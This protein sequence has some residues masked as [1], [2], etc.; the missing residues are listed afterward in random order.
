MENNNAQK[1][2]RTE[3]GGLE[4]YGHGGDLLTASRMY[5]LPPE[6]FVDFSSNMNP[7]GPPLS[8]KEQIVAYWPQ[9]VHYPDPAARGLKQKLSSHYHIPASCI[10]VGN[11]A[12]E[13]IDLVVRAFCPEKTA[14]LRPSFSEYELAI[15]KSG[16]TTVDIWLQEEHSFRLQQ[17]DLR[18][19]LCEADALFIGQPNNPTGQLVPASWLIELADQGKLV[20]VDE[21]FID[22]SAEERERSLIQKAAEHPHLIV[23]RSMTKFYAVP[24]IR[25]GFMVATQERILEVERLQVP[26]SVN[27]LAQR[28]GEAVLEDRKFAE[29]TRQWLEEERP[30]FSEK[31][32]ALGLKVMPSDA[33]YLLL[34]LPAGWTAQDMQR[35]LGRRGILIRDASRFPGLNESYCRVAIKKREDNLKLVEVLERML[36]E[37]G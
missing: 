33:N 29:Q 14:L 4:L 1:T 2:D 32:S 17:E 7:W 34:K 10:C 37:T 18:R 16:G 15:L 21:A 35:G 36:H 5:G 11:G 30:W 31:L 9:I 6:Q 12:A 8:V 20:I 25:L 22:F 13:L 26:W 23:L 19:A 3:T 24:G 27:S 28:I